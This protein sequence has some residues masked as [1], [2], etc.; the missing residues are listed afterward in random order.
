V[1]AQI[2]ARAIAF[3]VLTN[4][5]LKLVVGVFV[6]VKSFRR[7]VGIGLAAIALMLTISLLILG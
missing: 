6:G 4:T 2:A 1:P 5:V 3:G 7:I